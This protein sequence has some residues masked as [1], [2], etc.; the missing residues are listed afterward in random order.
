MRTSTNDSA[1]PRLAKI[2]R[3]MD[4]VLEPHLADLIEIERRAA[5]GKGGGIDPDEINRR[6]K[7][8][9]SIRQAKI[10]IPVVRMIQQAP[11]KSVREFWQLI[12]VCVQLSGES[13]HDYAC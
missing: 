10:P 9:R 2:A 6:N 8:S 3:K 5:T 1:L 4:C 12:Q 11:K 7:L 13:H